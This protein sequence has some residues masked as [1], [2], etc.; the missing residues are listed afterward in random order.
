MNISYDLDKYTGQFN[1]R[2]KV[3][4]VDMEKMKVVS[5][6]SVQTESDLIEFQL[7]HERYIRKMPGRN[8]FAEI[9]ITRIYQGYDHFYNWRLMIEEGIDL[10]KDVT[11]DILSPDLQTVVRSM[12]LQNCWPTRWQLPNLDANSNE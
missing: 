10:C 5:V 3:D 8:K 9:E 12:K 6:Q 7:G 4:G 11:V 2:I 1:F